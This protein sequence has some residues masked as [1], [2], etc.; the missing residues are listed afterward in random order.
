MSSSRPG[1]RFLG[2]GG[3]MIAGAGAWFAACGQSAPS[4]ATATRPDSPTNAALQPLVEAPPAPE[5]AQ[6]MGT[7]QTLTHKLALAAD[8]GNTPLAAFY[9]HE[10]R[11]QLRTIQREAP[12]YENLPVAVLIERLALPAYSDLE[13]ITGQPETSRE[14]LLAG[15][16]RVVQTCNEC[17][18]AT[19]HGFIRITRGTDVNPYNQSFHQP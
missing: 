4:F 13:K 17:H 11:E 6:L 16:D 2:I 7:L 1:F 9:L 3:L 19:Q 8:A 12:D 5:L 10:S 18:R 14:G 15:L